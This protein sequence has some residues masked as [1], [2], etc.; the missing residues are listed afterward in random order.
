MGAFLFLHQPRIARRRALLLLPVQNAHLPTEPGPNNLNTPPFSASSLLHADVT[1]LQHG[2]CCTNDASDLPHWTSSL[3]LR[4]AR[5]LARVG[6]EGAT[7]HCL[8][9][10]AC[11]MPARVSPP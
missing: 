1:A 2:C 11:R 8:M 10:T 3:F 4:I 9:L 7:R 5:F 6:Q